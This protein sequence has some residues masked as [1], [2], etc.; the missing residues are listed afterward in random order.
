MKGRIYY[1]LDE[2]STFIPRLGSLRSGLFAGP[3]SQPARGLPRAFLQPCRSGES[4]PHQVQY[5]P[6]SQRWARV[7][8]G[9]RVPR[10]PCSSILLS[11]SMFPRSCTT[12]FLR[13][14][15]SRIPVL[16]SFASFAAYP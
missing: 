9:L 6:I 2:N 7:P 15:R 16:R 13:S 14:P 12:F 3:D 4:Q 11:R 10:A 5:I 8:V 1:L